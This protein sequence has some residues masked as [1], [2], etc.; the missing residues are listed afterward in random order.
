VYVSWFV[1]EN[2]VSYIATQANTKEYFQFCAF[3][4]LA[5]RHL[6]GHSRH[7]VYRAPHLSLHS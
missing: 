4:D 3:M 7:G 2:G 1:F 6:A 5:F